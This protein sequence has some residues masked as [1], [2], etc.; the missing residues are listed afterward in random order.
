MYQFGL[1]NKQ[2]FERGSWS[3]TSLWKALVA[4]Y[5]LVEAET[6]G[7]DWA[8]LGRGLRAAGGRQ[9]GLVWGEFC[10]SQ[11]S[12]V[13][14]SGWM[15]GGSVKTWLPKAQ[16]D[17]A[18]LSMSLGTGEVIS[19]LRAKRRD[20]ASGTFTGVWLCLLAPLRFNFQIPSV[21]CHMLGGP[22]HY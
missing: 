4:E 13:P 15:Q 20:S 6:Q 14:A 8:S 16:R 2:N 10:C 19:L 21:L 11:R 1:P 18:G 12:V 17:L 5:Y 22:D 7:G 9:A 3:C